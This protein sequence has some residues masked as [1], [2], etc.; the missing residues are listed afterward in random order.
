MG[1]HTGFVYLHET[2]RKDANGQYRDIIV[3]NL[4]VITPLANIKFK[5]GDHYYD[6][7]RSLFPKEA[8]KYLKKQR[9]I[10][11]KDLQGWSLPRLQEVPGLGPISGKRIIKCLK[12]ANVKHR[13]TGYP[14]ELKLTIQVPI[15]D[16]EL[17]YSHEQ[18]AVEDALA[19]HVANAMDV[20]PQIQQ[21]LLNKK[22]ADLRIEERILEQN[23]K[24]LK[25][26]LVAVDA[27][28]A[29]R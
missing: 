4:P 9:V 17:L 1:T 20:F 26:R 12:H 21:V 2:S 25:Q 22:K 18:E 14:W 15:A 10:V 28:A 5:Q 29:E 11:I 13:G 19:H 23:L 24:A 27:E 16:V 3:G 7:N 8:L 6:N